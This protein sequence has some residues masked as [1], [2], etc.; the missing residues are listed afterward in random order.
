MAWMFKVI[1]R[2]VP[3]QFVLL[4]K[5]KFPFATFPGNAYRIAALPDSYENNVREDSTAKLLHQSLGKYF[6]IRN[7]HLDMV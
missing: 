1:L 4:L 6:K 5:R 2:T 7:R 3:I